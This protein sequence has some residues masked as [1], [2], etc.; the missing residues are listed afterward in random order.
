M[1][2]I[3]IDKTDWIELENNL[4]NKEATIVNIKKVLELL[5]M[6]YEVACIETNIDPK[7][8]PAYLKAKELI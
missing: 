4:K 6:A 3:L 5:C 2:N 8:V 1:N 7:A